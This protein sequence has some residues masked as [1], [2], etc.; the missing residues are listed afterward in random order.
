M[1]SLE[2][3]NRAV[4]RKT[5]CIDLSQL[6][7]LARDQCDHKKDEKRGEM[8][9]LARGHTPAAGWLEKHMVEMPSGM[10]AK[11]LG[12]GGS[13]RHL[14]RNHPSSEREKQP[15]ENAAPIT[16]AGR[17]KKGNDRE[18]AVRE[19]SVESRFSLAPS[20]DAHTTS[21]SAGGS[22]SSE[23]PSHGRTRKKHLQGTPS[24]LDR[25][26]GSKVT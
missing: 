14:L 9:H 2:G 5:K 24:S 7:R 15:D 11:E 20:K 6:Q 1:V 3:G 10:G 4:T 21:Q 18:Q 12:S 16:R 13:Y 19:E 17:M 23:T 25:D 26:E 8:Q 22:S